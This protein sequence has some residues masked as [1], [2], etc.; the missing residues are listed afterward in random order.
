MVISV[1][2]CCLLSN[3]PCATIF[4]SWKGNMIRPVS[5]NQEGAKRDFFFKFIY[6]LIC[7]EFCHTLEWNSHGFP[8]VPHPDPPS[9][10]PLHPLPLGFPSAPGPSACL[11]HPTKPGLMAPIWAHT[12]DSLQNRNTLRY[13]G[14]PKH[15]HVHCRLL[16]LDTAVIRQ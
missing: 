10:L 14:R 7:S 13:K 6:F 12:L 2:S 15:F 4:T 3:K 9:H 1:I 11:M 5:H 8:C 16:S